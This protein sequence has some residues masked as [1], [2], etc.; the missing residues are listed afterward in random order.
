MRAGVAGLLSALFVLPAWAEVIPGSDY[1]YGNWNGAAYTASDSGAFSHCVVSA[2]YVS[3]DTLYLSVNSNAS[4]TIGVES[5]TLRLAEGQEIPVTVRIDRRQP[6]YGKAVAVNETFATLVLPDIKAALPALQRGRTLVVE[7]ALGTGYY[8]LTGTHRALEATLNCAVNYLDYA[9]A[10]VPG[11]N[12][13][14][15]IDRTVLFQVAT[16]MIADMGVKDF[17]YLTEQETVADFGPS[18][19]VWVSESE[20]LVGGV[21]AK[22]AAGLTDL[23]ETD[24]Q[25]IAFMGEGCDGDVATTSRT[26]EIESFQA[27][28]LRAICV[29]SEG[30]TEGLLT[31][32][33]LGESVIYTVLYFDKANGSVA[34]AQRQEMSEKAALQA[35]KYVVEHQE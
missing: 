14:S 18:S 9:A 6:F 30:T 23:R 29:T 2:G 35:A 19:V 27:R 3:G 34:P 33:L 32:T 11:A 24:P 10:P 28:E 7:S 21:I 31:K 26:F 4:V 25:D 17:R 8:D 22:P 1:G 16:G 12:A 20:G 5:P 13:S 15:A